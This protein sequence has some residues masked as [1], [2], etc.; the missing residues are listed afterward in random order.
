M[1]TNLGYTSNDGYSEVASGTQYASA[2]KVG[3]AESSGVLASCSV[4]IKDHGSDGPFLCYAAIYDDSG[5]NNRPGTLLAGPYSATVTLDNDGYVEIDM[6]EAELDIDEGSTY[7]VA[8]S[9]ANAAYRLYQNFSIGSYSYQNIG[10]PDNYP[11]TWTG[12]VPTSGA[13]AAYL[14]YGDP[15][16]EGNTKTSVLDALVT[17]LQGVTGI[18]TATRVL[19]TPAEARKKSPYAGLIASTEEVVVEDSTHVRYELDVDVIL[20]KKGRD[21]ET[22]LDAV[23]NLLYSTSLAATIGAKQIRI[24]GQEEVALVDA[25]QYSSTRIAM[26]IT[27]VATKGSF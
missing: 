20:L 11:S 12:S 1:A 8:F 25:D 22:L 17:Q 18:T 19:L 9:C 23:K 3:T 16:P 14:T 6:S 21:I 2:V 5:A 24:V 15:V 10:T 27:Y 4:A 26:T 13:C 7:W